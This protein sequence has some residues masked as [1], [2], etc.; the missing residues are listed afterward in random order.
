LVGNYFVEKSG[1]TFYQ[2]FL[3]RRKA[4]AFDIDVASEGHDIA[5]RGVFGFLSYFWRGLAEITG[6][7]GE[8]REDNFK[9]F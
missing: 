7:C 4:G 6:D 3:G 5:A 9:D 1:Y 8:E 2:L